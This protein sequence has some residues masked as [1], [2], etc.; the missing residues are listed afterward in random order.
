MLHILAST[1]IG[2][3]SI[4]CRFLFLGLFCSLFFVFVLLLAF[5]GLG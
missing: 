4:I 1:L 2:L 3:S 5:P